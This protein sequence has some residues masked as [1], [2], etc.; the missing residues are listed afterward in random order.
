MSRFAAFAFDAYGTLF[1]V[2]S[3]T[4]LAERLVPGQGL[5][6]AQIWRTKQLEYSWL[7]SL[8]IGPTFARPDFDAITR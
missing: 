3:V 8:M 1:D 4:A 7:A 6:L 5:T 2:F